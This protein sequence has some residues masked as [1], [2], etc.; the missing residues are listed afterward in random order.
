M[1]LALLAFLAFD[2]WLIHKRV[3]YTREIERL[4]GGMSETERRRTDML[5]EENENKYRVMLELIRRQAQG[6]KE[7]HLSIALDSG[8]MYLERE[9]AI[10]R[11]MRMEVG[12]EAW[13]RNGADSVLMAAPRGTRT[14]EKILGLEDAWEVPA[15]VYSQRGLPVPAERALRGALGPVA[16]VLNGGTVIYSVPTAG[17]LNDSSYVLPGSIRARINDLRAVAP[18]LQAGTNVYFY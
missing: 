17:P 2:G 13:V 11:E 18:N 5:V 6:D 15:W 16:V 3:K 4:R 9:G 1:G 7:L 8:E 14:V 12:P 10:L